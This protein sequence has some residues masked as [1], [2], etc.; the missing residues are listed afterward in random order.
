MANETKKQI[1]T[2]ANGLLGAQAK[3]STLDSAT[4]LDIDTEKK[5]V[6]TLIQG[7]TNGKLNLNDLDH[8]TSISN[9]RD[10]VYQLIDTMAQ[11]SSISAI[12]KV[13]AGEVCEPNDNGHIVWCESDDPKISKFINY[14]LNV[15]NVDKNIYSWVYCLLKYGD[16]Y[17]KL[18]RE[19]DYQ[20][21]LFSTDKVEKVYSA[22]NV[23]NETLNKAVNEQVILSTHGIKDPYSFYIEMIND[24]STMYEVSK[25]GKTYGYIETPNLYTPF[26][27]TSTSLPTGN[28][29]GTFNFKMKSSE[30]IIHQADDYVHACLEDNFS[31]F[32]ETIDLLNTTHHSAELD[33]QT[34]SQRYNVRRGK[35]ILYDAYKV[36]REKQLLEGA[37]LLNRL[38]KSS[39]FR[40]VEVEVGDMGQE[41][42]KQLL[43]RVKEMFEAKTSYKAGTEMSETNSPGP[44]ENFI[45]FAKRN[46]VG[47]VS[48]DSVGGD[49]NVKDLADLDSWN[50]KLYAAFGIPKQFFGY[51]EDGAGFNGG[52]SL[53]IISSVFAKSVKRV[54]N[55]MIQAITDAANLMLVNKGLTAYL[56]N[57]TIKMKAPVTQEEIDY[58]NDL[59]NRISNISNLQSLFADVED[60]SR[61]LKLLKE[62]IAQ[63]NYGDQINAILNDEIEAAEAKAKE[64][65]EQAKAEA[66]AE[67]ELDANSANTDSTEIDTDEFDLQ[68]AEESIEIDESSEILTE[69]M[70]A[71][72]ESDFIESTD[73]LPTPDELDADRDFTENN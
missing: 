25:F 31:R 5:F 12:L 18:Y 58:R 49:V 67:A 27:I 54:Q 57:F 33:I 71:L 30:V 36:W 15:V 23:L 37:V 10:Q 13:Y 28:F 68:P 69:E 17:L 39:I 11:D 65:A 50:N 51:T 9:S 20:D 32:P 63:L 21:D 41:Q 53:A 59:T 22:R 64:E 38:T 2:T 72:K 44:I 26:D 34:N 40:K 1:K 46:N 70:P 56:N 7:A 43:R 45:Y 48:I 4:K 52:S 8:F 66:E 47:S 14:W 16:V 62:F 60:K 61:R 6:D 42:V 73:D 55:A 35:S 3:P 19:S 29:G 24:P